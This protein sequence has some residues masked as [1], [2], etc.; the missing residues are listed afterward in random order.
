VSARTAVVG[1]GLAG[2]TA[3]LA[4]ADRGEDVVLLE[5]QKRLGGL[6]GSFRREGPAGPLDVDTGQ[7]V[8]LRCC[9]AYRALLARLGTSAEVTL[10]ERLTIPVARP[11]H[12]G[13]GPGAAVLRRGGLPAPMHLAGALSRYRLLSRTDRLRV[14]R[15]ALALRRVDPADP[16]ADGMTFGEWLTG[17]RQ[18]DRTIGTLWDLLGVAALNAPADAT[19]LALAA[20]VF[21]TGLLDEAAAA[22]IGWSRIPLQRL[23]GTA[24]GRC[25]AAAGAEVCLGHRV[26]SLTRQGH[27]WLLRTRDGGAEYADQ[28][29][30]AVPPAAAERLLPAGAVRQQPGWSDRLGTVPIVNVHVVYERPV[31]AT[32]FLAAV[33]SPVQWIFDRTEPADLTGGGQYLAVSLSAAHEAVRRRSTELLQAVLPALAALLPAARGATVLDGFVTRE[34]AATF[35]PAPGQAALRPPTVTAEAGLVLAGAWTATGWPATMEGAVRSGAAAAAALDG[36]PAT[37]RA[38]VGRPVAA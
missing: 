13:T 35:A 26:E 10:Q 33:G 7:H 18:N 16:A 30:L 27:G 20:M 1:G 2:L 29:V 38:A 17:H 19:S 3:A 8:F 9:T 36:A 14:A 15:A 6:T 28:V 23:H 5:A 34:R 24:G 31:L 37:R 21:R 11:D 4:L 12:D 32:P 25:L 22:D